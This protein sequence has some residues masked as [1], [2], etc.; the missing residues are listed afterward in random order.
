M[1]SVCQKT[2][3]LCGFQAEQMPIF[4]CSD[5]FRCVPFSVCNY[6]NQLDHGHIAASTIVERNAQLKEALETSANPT[7]LLRRCFTKT[8]ELLRTKTYLTEMYEGIELPDPKD[9]ANIPTAKTIS[10]I[11]FKFPHKGKKKN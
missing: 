8:W 6:Q 4:I 1:C 3:C 10:K 2:Q 5:L 9:P 11:V 7:Q